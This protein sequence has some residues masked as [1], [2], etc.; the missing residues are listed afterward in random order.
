MK[1]SLTLSLLVAL[2]SLLAGC[3][4]SR[5]ERDERKPAA[6]PAAAFKA[7]HGLRLTP[8]AREFN[9]IAT[10]EFGGR[11]PVAAILRTV[12]GAFVYVENDGWFLRTPITM[13]ATDG[14]SAEIKE[15]LYDGDRAVVSGVRALWLAE[16]HV[17]RAGQACAHEG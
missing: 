8:F 10:A 14:V 6:E 11:L 2:S 1:T 4:E 9:G 13:G 5:A 16:L 7:G 15:G 17:L 12:E 3:G